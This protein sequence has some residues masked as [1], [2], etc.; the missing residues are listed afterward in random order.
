M[1]ILCVGHQSIQLAPA[2]DCTHASRNECHHTDTPTHASTHF[3][4]RTHTHRLPWR[5]NPTKWKSN[6]L[7][8]PAC[9][10]LSV[11]PSASGARRG[12]G[13]LVRQPPIHSRQPHPMTLHG[14]TV[15]RQ[16]PI[17]RHERREQQGPLSLVDRKDQD[18]VVARHFAGVRHLQRDGLG[19]LIL[20]LC[21]GYS[22]HA[23]RL[24]GPESIRPAHCL[25]HE[26]I[27]R[28]AQNSGDAEGLDVQVEQPAASQEESNT[29]RPNAAPSRPVMAA[30]CDESAN[31]KEHGHNEEN[32]GAN[33]GVR[34][35]VVA[36]P[37]TLPGQ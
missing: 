18:A 29:N 13:R 24:V 12:E 22:Q 19:C 31:E 7:S 6:S 26:G 8:A 36:N 1:L 3:P 10:H 21:I 14:T 28:S 32:G 25:Q 9:L 27:G 35:G 15:V 4:P 37:V 33:D 16:K 2:I 30:Q 11:R 23:G 17:G 20:V 5:Q 34:L